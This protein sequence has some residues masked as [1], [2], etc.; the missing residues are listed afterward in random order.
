[1]S[2][3]KHQIAVQKRSE[4]GKNAS[5]RAR[6][7]GL[8]PVIV[9]AKGEAGVPYYVKAGDWEALSHHELHLVYLVDGRQETAA[10][11]KDVQVN[12]LKNH[13]L[14]IDFQAVDLNAEIHSEVQI[15]PVGE[16]YGAAHGGILEQVIHQITVSCK[17]QDIPE[18]IGV[19]VSKLNIGD[20][21]HVSDIVLPAGVKLVGDGEAIVFHVVHEQ[22]EEVEAPAAEELTEPEAIKQKGP[23]EPKEGADKADKKK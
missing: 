11:V 6:R 9:Y 2:K 18:S 13:V 4:F 16:A 22:A 17:A 5:R 21:L 20:A 3:E 23:A 15:H 8:V 1:M 14:H 10:L 19:D 12:Y 7:D